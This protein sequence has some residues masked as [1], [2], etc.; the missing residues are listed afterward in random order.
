LQL[1][2]YLDGERFDATQIAHEPWRDLVNHP[3][4]KDLVLLECGLRASRVTRRGKQFFKHYP[5]VD[6]PIEHK[7]ESDQ[8]LAMKR[9]LKDRINAVDGWYGEV[10]EAHPDRAWIADVMAFHTSGRR[11]AFEVQLSQQSEDEYIRRSQRYVDDRIGPVWVVPDSHDEF[12]VKLPMIVT[13]FGKSSDMPEVPAAL[14]ELS[15]YQPILG[16]LARVGIM[17][18]RVLHDSFR[19]P[20]GSPK[21]QAEEIARLDEQRA[22]DAEIARLKAADQAAAKSRAGLEEARRSAERDALFLDRAE[23]P[24]VN[25]TPAVAAAMNIWA[26]K[27]RCVTSGHPMLIWRLI[28]PPVRIDLRPYRPGPESFPH[29]SAPVTAWLEAKGSGLA[30]GKLVPIQGAGNRL[31]FSCPECNEVVQG[32]WV[33]ALPR[34]KWSAIAEG[35]PIGSQAREVLYRKPS[36]QPSPAKAKPQES[37]VLRY[38]AEGDLRFIGP[39]RKAY[40]MSEARDAKEIIERHAAKD[41]R[42]VRMQEVRDNPRYRASPNGFRFEC[43][44]CGGVFEDDNEGIHADARCRVPGARNSG[45]R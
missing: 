40:W 23:A 20:H 44:D 14:M 3:G 37:V 27:V 13:G 4:Y 5:E 22:N 31:A 1:V 39:R 42:A 16:H 32:R 6:C 15:Q 12:R 26:S 33:A 36:T 19:W 9:A 28:E 29:V 25:E 10:E 43:T 38:M 35:N 18:D 2:A 7:S 8:H 34:D 21:Q 17:V 24:D 45:W 30:K 41:A 11:L